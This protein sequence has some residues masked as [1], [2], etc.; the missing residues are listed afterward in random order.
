M[1]IYQ[2]TQEMMLFVRFMVSCG[3]HDAIYLSCPVKSTNVP[4][5]GVGASKVAAMLIGGFG[6]S[7]GNKGRGSAGL[8]G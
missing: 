8:V 5:C 1:F 2:L 4:Q 7:R 6:E 3:L